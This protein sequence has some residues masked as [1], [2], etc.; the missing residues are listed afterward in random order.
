MTS[1]SLLAGRTVNVYTQ[2]LLDVLI[3]RFDPMHCVQNL[4]QNSI[5]YILLKKS[6]DPEEAS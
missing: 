2:L 1:L 5:L 3:T 6:V 4:F